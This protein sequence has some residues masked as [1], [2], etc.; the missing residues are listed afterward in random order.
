VL[1]QILIPIGLQDR[2][3]E[4]A[5]A[6]L[7]RE[8]CGLLV[9]TK[10]GEILRIVYVRPTRN[11]ATQPDAFEID[12]AAHIALMRALRGTERQIIGCY[13][14]HPNGTSEPSARD[15][16][17]SFEQGLVWL[18]AGLSCRKVQLRAFLR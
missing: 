17:A 18:I 7:P 13:H 15:L 8:S 5:R 3:A 12:P 16:A 4:D 6:A 2:I 11:V 14:S 9:G 1:R 10:R